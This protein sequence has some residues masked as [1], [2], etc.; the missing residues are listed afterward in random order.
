M[1]TNASYEI[2]LRFPS[3][4][5]YGREEVLEGV[6]IA[7]MVSSPLAAPRSVTPAV[8]PCFCSAA[9]EQIP[10]LDE[11]SDPRNLFAL[12]SMS[13]VAF[14]LCWNLARLLLRS[15]LKSLEYGFKSSLRL[16]SDC[17]APTI[18]VDAGAIVQVSQE[19]S[20]HETSSVSASRDGNSGADRHTQ[21]MLRCFVS[22]AAASSRRRGALASRPHELPRAPFHD[23][24][25]T[26][27]CCSTLNVSW[28][29][30]IASSWSRSA[31]RE[32]SSPSFEAC[33]G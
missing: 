13:T 24:T 10:D 12:F 21:C 5:W 14:F 11:L 20:E 4:A 3:T 7:K 2:L 22:R 28:S 33:P 8:S 23:A 29:H 6:A 32:N 30:S 17:V 25:W 9:L 27:A 31:L 19:G 16:V 1:S 18:P 15:R 26:P